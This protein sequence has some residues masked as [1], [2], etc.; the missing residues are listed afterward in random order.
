MDD[1]QAEFGVRWLLRRLA[2]CPNAYYNYRKHRKADYYTQKAKVQEQIRDICHAHNGVDGYRGMT[3]Y[4]KR[5]EH[6]YSA[7]T[8]H[9][10]M[11]VEMGSR[12]IGRPKKPG[13]RPGKPHKVFENRL[14]QDFDKFSCTNVTKQLDHYGPKGNVSA[15]LTGPC[16][17]IQGGGT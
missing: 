16:T 7:A 2:L 15:K 17:I 14:K 12:S 3:V 13:A 1:Y 6:G 11:N 8:I 5:E 9:K 10:Y 4:L